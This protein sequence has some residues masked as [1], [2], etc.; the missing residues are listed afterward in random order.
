MIRLFVVVEGQTE[1]TFVKS[2]LTPHLAERGVFC[3]AIVIT[4]SREVSGVKRRGGGRWKHW[5]RDIRR[6]TIQ[7]GSA[8]RFTTMFDLYGLPEDFPRLNQ[9][10]SVVDTNQRA[11]LLEIAMGQVVDDPR[12]IPYLQRHEFEALVLSCLGTL[13]TILEKAD[14][15]QGVAELQR[16]IGSLQPED[17]NDGIDTAPSKRILQYVPSYQKVL[18]GPLALEAA[19]LAALRAKCPRFDAW[20]TNLEGLGQQP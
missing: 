9:H 17:V 8:V 20:I 1:E 5:E 19:G 14:E 16:S 3:S 15:R 11:A 7:R 18:H 12:F 13:M 2:M 4:T 6:L 10:G